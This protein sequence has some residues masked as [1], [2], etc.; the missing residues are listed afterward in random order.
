MEKSAQIFCILEGILM[1]IVGILFFIKPMDSLLYFT[2]VAGILIIGSGIFTII[3]AFK[4]SKNNF[5]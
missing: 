3:K 4:S 1:A 2:I 5:V